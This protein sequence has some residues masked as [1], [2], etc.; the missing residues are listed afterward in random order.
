MSGANTHERY[1][2]AIR[3]PGQTVNALFAFLD[4]S[5]TLASPERVE[6]KLPFR[7]ELTQGAKVVAGGILATLADEAMAHVVIANLAPNQ[8]TATTE[9]AVRYF[10]AVPH[11]EMTAVATLVHKG[12]RIMSAE[13]VITDEKGRMAV[14]AS[15]SFYVLDTPA[16]WASV[17]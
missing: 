16:G 9:M 12:R 17:P 4:L 15:G 10:R 1:F 6:L 11:G 2:E 8:T 3:K 14:K 5:L 7:P 13:V